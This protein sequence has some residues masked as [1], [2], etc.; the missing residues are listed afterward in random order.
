MKLLTFLFLSCFFFSNTKAQTVRQ[1]CVHYHC[2][3]PSTTVPN[4]E[5]IHGGSPNKINDCSQVSGKLSFKING[6]PYECSGTAAQFYTTQK[7]FL[8]IT[9]FGKLNDSS[10]LLFTYRVKPQTA[11]G[12]NLN[13]RSFVDYGNYQINIGRSAVYFHRDGGTYVNSP[14]RI[15][16]SC[17]YKYST[18]QYLLNGTFSGTL[19]TMAGE[20]VQITDG[21]FCSNKFY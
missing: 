15:N 17:A 2:D 9:I 13:S 12:Q 16:V 11:V 10:Q 5:T 7:N 6:V 3:N 21:V 8:E 4:C 1:N 18:N 14:L 20:A 19:F